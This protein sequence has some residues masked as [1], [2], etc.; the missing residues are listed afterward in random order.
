[1][2]ST[3]I[4]SFNLRPG[5]V[6][7]GKYEVLGRLGRGYEGEV[8]KL[9]ELNT[10]I[11][12]AGKLF[13]PHRNPR[14]RAVRFFATKLH[15]LRSCPI[16]I[17]YVT[18]EQVIHRDFEITLLVSELVEGRLLSKFIRR[19]P[20][21]RLSVFESLHLLYTMAAGL[22]AI[23]GMGEYHGD[24][25]DENILIQRQG[26]FFDVKLVDLYY[27]GRPSQSLIQEDIVQ[28]VRIFYDSLGGA[29]TYA[30]HPEHVKY[31]CAGLKR[32]LLARRFRNAGQLRRHLERLPWEER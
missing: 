13:F 6:I 10:R 7:A 1:M 25:H 20:G 8:Y 11:E 30:G 9:R 22:E 32:S 3:R 21:R 2:A 15:R 24:I 5:R 29:R 19:Q 26:I 16:L 23:H 18:Q 31:I 12:R 27:H 4:T 28:L 14:D 17:R